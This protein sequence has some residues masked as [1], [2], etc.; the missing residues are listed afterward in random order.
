MKKRFMIAICCL[1]LLMQLLPVVPMAET[2]VARTADKGAVSQDLYYCRSELAKLPNGA[3]LVAAYDRIVD[4][5]NKGLDSIDIQ[6]T[7]EEFYLVFDSTRRDHT[8]QFWV[9]S[10]YGT[11]P[12]RFDQNIVATFHPEYTMTGKALTDAKVAFEEAVSK[13]FLDRLSPDMSEYEMEKALH[14]MIAT[15][16]V[17][18]TGATNAHNAYGAIVEGVAVCEGYAESLQYLLQRV[19]IQSVEV[20]GYGI[21]D[22]ATGAGENHAWNIVRI[23][24]AYYC[25]DLT[26]DDHGEEN[27]LSYAYFNQNDATFN[28]DH[29]AWVMGYENGANWDGGFEFPACT[30]TAANYYTKN[31]LRIS[32]YDANS[33]GA[34]LQNNKLSVTVYV[35]GDVVT[36]LAWYG[37]NIREIAQAAGVTGSFKY[38]HTQNKNEVHLIIETCGHTQLDTV[39]AKAATCTE[40]GNT[41]YYV[42]QNKSCGK[43]FSDAEAKLEILNKDLVKVLSSGHVW[44]RKEDEAAIKDAESETY[45][46]TCSTCGAVSD[47]LF[48]GPEPEAP[49]EP[50]FDLNAIIDL[51]LANPFI[52]GG[53]GGGILLIVIIAVIRKMRG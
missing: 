39:E 46:Y 20:L 24:G 49:E 19:G 25:V 45:W 51:I 47:T 26:W 52:L 37:E 23:D 34:L 42:C 9:D 29:K 18:T 3:A 41:A 44:E 38:G 30:S 16:V 13:K 4:G 7:K 43:W 6:L 36:F 1:V 14:D 8:E 21:T 27:F 33:I 12:D 53:G 5:I 35:D 10:T 22:P 28:A 15:Q 40:D 32:N 11:T 50:A 48:F 17:Y 2:T 31:N